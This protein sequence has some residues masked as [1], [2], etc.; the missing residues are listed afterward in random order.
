MRRSKSKK[1]GFT[2]VEVLIA[3]AIL[4]VAVTCALQVYFNLSFL[5]SQSRSR[6]VAVVHAESILDEIRSW[7]SVI[8]SEIENGPSSESWDTWL[9]NELG[10]DQNNDLLTDET[11]QVEADDW[12]EGVSDPPR[13]VTITVSWNQ[14]GRDSSLV[15]KGVVI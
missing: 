4:T 6:T 15:L 5:V 3:F 13:L 9:I 12:V 2:F 11:V 7:D 14:K 10:L 8:D 1:Q